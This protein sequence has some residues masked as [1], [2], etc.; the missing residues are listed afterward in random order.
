[1]GRVEGYEADTERGSGVDHG[2]VFEL[3]DRQRAVVS[4]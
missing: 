1:V 4:V 3:E 2:L